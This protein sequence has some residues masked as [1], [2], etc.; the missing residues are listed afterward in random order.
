MIIKKPDG[1]VLIN[2]PWESGVF[3]PEDGNQ[4]YSIKFHFDAP[5]QAVTFSLDASSPAK[6]TYTMEVYYKGKLIG[7]LKKTMS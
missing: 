2:S 7:L 5:G 1:K 6:G 4:I 3:Q